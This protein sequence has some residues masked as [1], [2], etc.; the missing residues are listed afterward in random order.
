MNAFLNTLEKFLTWFFALSFG[1]LA[2]FLVM[3]WND[4]RTKSADP[5]NKAP[6]ANTQDAY[7][8]FLRS[9]HGC[10]KESAAR[11][12]LDALQRREGL[13]SRLAQEHLSERASISFPSFTPDAKTLLASGGDGPDFW[14][15]ET[16][17]R[18]SLGPKTFQR[19]GNPALMSALDLSP[20]G[21]KVAVG[22]TG[23]E[24][25]RLLMWDLGQEAFIGEHE[26]EGFDVRQVQFAPDNNWLAWRGDGPVGVWNPAANKF[27][28]ANHQG[29]S[30]LAFLDAAGKRFLLTASGHELWFWEP[31]S[32]TLLKEGRVDSD[33]PLLGLTR[34]GRLVLFSD[35]RVLEVWDT[36]T[37]REAATLRDLAG[38]ITAFCRNL[39]SGHL[40]VGTSQGMVYFWDFLNSAVPYAHVAAH[41]GPV[42]MLRCGPENRLVSLGFDGAKVWGEEGI[43]ASTRTTQAP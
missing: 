35:G 15:A 3:R 21:H 43:L 12:A 20:A 17:K 8:A 40:L 18:K 13:I 37:G 39:S 38:E 24:G 5:W 32:L 16:G 19:L 4:Q 30:D 42:E 31:T 26:V 22:T 29:V 27:F 10:S 23:R 36:V 11:E 28:R 6:A 1:A 7:V 9:C 33:R 2:V 34:D 25:G 41:A 14:D